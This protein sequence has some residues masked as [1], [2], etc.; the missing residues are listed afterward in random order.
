MQE[1]KNSEKYLIQ[2]STKETYEIPFLNKLVTVFTFRKYLGRI[3]YFSFPNLEIW[4]KRN[5]QRKGSYFH[6][7]TTMEN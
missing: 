5:I 6:G 7:D 4:K 3:M 1:K 2:M